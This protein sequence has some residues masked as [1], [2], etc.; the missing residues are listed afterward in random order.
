MTL[1]TED[2][3]SG[4]GKHEILKGVNVKAEMGKITGLIGPNGAG[5]S[6]LLKT[7][8]GY[9][10]TKKGKAFFKDKEI[11]NLDPRAMLETGI[12]Y[13]AQAEGLF[14]HMTVR[15]NLRLG[16]FLIKDKQVLEERIERVLSISNLKSRVKQL[17]GSLS[18][19]ERRILEIGRGLMLNPEMVLL[20]EPSAALAPM[21]VDTVFEHIRQINEENQTSFLIVE[22]DVNLILEKADY[23]FAMQL[24]RMV[25][26]GPPDDFRKDER[27][28]TLFL[29]RG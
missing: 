22:Q 11:T 5:K 20:D 10:K 21:L 18:G 4:Y 13:V 1:R 12:S 7:I 16:G 2:V 14:P 28:R 29:G 26:G 25:H 17:A 6:T 19:G 15:E 9:L 3:H 24:G 27:L 23:V 8:F